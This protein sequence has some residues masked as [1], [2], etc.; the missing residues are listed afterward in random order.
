MTDQIQLEDMVV[1]LVSVLI[2]ASESVDMIVATICDRG[3]DKASW[4]LTQGPCYPWTIAIEGTSTLDR[5]VGHDVGVV[6]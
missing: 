6:A 5:R 1:D 3:V 2:E 4:S